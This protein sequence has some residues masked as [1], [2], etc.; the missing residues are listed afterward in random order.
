VLT[1]LCSRYQ[2]ELDPDS[3]PGL[4]DRFELRFPGEPL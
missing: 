3:I 1:E 4:L 2:I